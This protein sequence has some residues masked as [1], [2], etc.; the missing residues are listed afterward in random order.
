MIN[1]RQFLRSTCTTVSVSCLASRTGNCQTT[2]INVSGTIDREIST[3]MERE[4]L[5]GASVAITQNGKLVYAS[6]F[7]FRDEALNQKTTANDRFRI[8]SISKS[9]T[10]AAVLKLCEIKGIGLDEKVVSHMELNATDKRITDV[11]IRHLL[12]HSSG[13]DDKMLAGGVDT[14]IAKWV[15]KEL[16]ITR[17]DMIR[18]WLARPFASNP[19][20]LHR[21]CNFGYV[22]LGML[23]EKISGM[24]YESFV[25]KEVLAPL[26][27]SK[28]EAG[29]TLIADARENE[30]FYHSDYG[31]SPS[32]MS[33][34]QPLLKG[35][36]GY[37]NM[38]NILS[39]GGWIGRAVDLARFGCGIRGQG[40]ASIISNEAR[41]QM[42]ARPS[43][44]RAKAKK[45][46]GLGVRVAVNSNK[47]K[48]FWHAGSI[49]GSSTHWGN[50]NDGITWVMLFNKRLGASGKE[51]S[52]QVSSFMH[53]LLDRLEKRPTK[54][55]F[56]SLL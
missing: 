46:Y 26:G 35:A 16:P 28:M 50:R 30:V 23:I 7:G 12:E 9:I 3:F 14:Y 29:K 4:K 17:D 15:Q 24:D 8:A 1:R 32:V 6:G 13:I 52:L 40:V 51:P 48:S 55:L 5:P 2:Q 36:Y 43:C 39:A 19:G 27:I 37:W 54:D 53:P 56:E 22:I 18:Y 44:T 45:Y 21:Y 41:K 10:A 34:D 25:K 47:E 42:L 31:N 33:S 38:E 11:T 49:D 20:E